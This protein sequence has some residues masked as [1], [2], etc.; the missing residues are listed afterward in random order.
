MNDT[1]KGKPTSTSPHSRR[2]VFTAHITE[3]LS[4][5]SG[6]YLNI[7]AGQVETKLDVSA[8][9]YRKSRGNEIRYHKPAIECHQ[10]VYSFSNVLGE[11]NRNVIAY[12]LRAK[13]QH[14]LNKWVK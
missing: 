6:C 3:V 11:I 10:A 4:S 14:D 9:I 13:S 8:L 7:V 1:R 5:G 2:D 12:V